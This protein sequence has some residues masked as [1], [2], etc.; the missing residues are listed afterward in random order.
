MTSPI[1][2]GTFYFT[3]FATGE[4]KSF[5]YDDRG[6]NTLQMFTQGR[7]NTMRGVVPVYLGAVNHYNDIA[8]YRGGTW[9]SN[10]GG[11]TVLRMGSAL[12]EMSYGGY[13]ITVLDGLPEGLSYEVEND[14]VISSGNDIQPIP[15]SILASIENPTNDNYP[16]NTT[17]NNLRCYFRIRAERLSMPEVRYSTWLYYFTVRTN[18]SAIRDAF[19]RNMPCNNYS[20]DQYNVVTNQQFIDRQKEDGYY[21]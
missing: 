1:P 10:S 6:G 13:R 16:V 18:W 12:A 9:Y 8:T 7:V 3:D 5:S 20:F 17:I 19:I 11:A 15:P 2:T 4:P 14:E 21:L